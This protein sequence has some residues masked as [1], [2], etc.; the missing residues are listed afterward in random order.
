MKRFLFIL[1][2]TLIQMISFSQSIEQFSVGVNGGLTYS[3]I[4][5]RN[6]WPGYYDFIIGYSTALNLEIK[7]KS[8]ISI[9]TNFG[10]YQNGYNYNVRDTFRYQFT[11]TPKSY[12]GI[13]QTITQNYLNN[14]WLLG[15]NV[16]NKVIFSIQAGIYWS[17]YLQSNNYFKSYYYIDSTDL[18]ELV[19][20]FSEGY[21]EEITTGKVDKKLYSN[22]DFGIAGGIK[23]GYNLNQKIELVLTSK[24][25]RGLVNVSNFDLI[26]GISHFNKSF[27][28]NFGINMKL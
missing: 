7:F 6:D 11:N 3:N 27:N 23:I 1:I 25:Y 12:I 5:E 10:F 22:L 28:F 8:K 4:S 26:E 17:I 19:P 14:S 21:H 20:A 9:E 18:A 13:D 2:F 24:Y 15:Y 16:G